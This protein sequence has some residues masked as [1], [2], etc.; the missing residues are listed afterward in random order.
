MINKPIENN[1]S[2]CCCVEETDHLHDKNG[3]RDL[4]ILIIGAVI[5][6]AGLIISIFTDSNQY[7]SFAVFV[8]SYLI[9]GGKIVLQAL[10][11]ITRRKIFDKNFL[12][13]IATIGAFITGE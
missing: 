13:S 2:S 12:M 4:T 1:C 9:L 3:R 8:V 11:P 6:G 5:F 7:I 10:K